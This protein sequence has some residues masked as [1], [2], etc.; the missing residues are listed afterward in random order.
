[1]RN[2]IKQ[3]IAELLDVQVNSVN[4]STTAADFL[5]WDSLMLLNITVEIEARFGVSIEPDDINELVSII[6]IENCIKKYN[7]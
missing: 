1:M 6:S 3:M 5:N 4:D 2:R 7:L